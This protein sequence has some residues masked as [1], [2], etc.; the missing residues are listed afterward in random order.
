MASAAWG[1]HPG[2]QASAI[3]ETWPGT[4]GG[5]D[6]PPAAATHGSIRPN[7]F[8]GH[9]AFELQSCKETEM[10]SAAW[11]PPRFTQAVDSFKSFR[12]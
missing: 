3:V 7:E 4:P 11:P 1:R 9:T 12:A 5:Q 8:P 10:S 2:T 6:R